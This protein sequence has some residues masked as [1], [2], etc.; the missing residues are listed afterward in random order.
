MLIFV[1]DDTNGVEIHDNHLGGN[2][3]L[4]PL[5]AW[6]MIDRSSLSSLAKTES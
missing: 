1:K 5:Q 6:L 4:E 3:L 2:I